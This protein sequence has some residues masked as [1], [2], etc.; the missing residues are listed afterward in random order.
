MP[1]LA[2][3][4]S[5]RLAILTSKSLAGINEW[6]SPRRT[7]V[8]FAMTSAEESASSQ[9]SDKL[10]ASHVLVHLFAAAHQ[11]ANTTPRGTGFLEVLRGLCNTVM[12]E[13]GQC[14]RRADVGARHPAP[15]MGQCPAR[16]PPGAAETTPAP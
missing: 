2:S 10:L 11:Y 5:V 3:K 14:E 15:R 7:C 6:P 4:S 13:A 9:D 16:S 1:I 8:R 12:V